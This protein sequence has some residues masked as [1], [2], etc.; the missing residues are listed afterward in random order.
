M[1]D[2]YDFSE[3]IKNPYIKPQKTTVTIRLDKATVDYFKGLS[4]EVN[5]PYQTLINAYLADCAA[6]Q[7]KPVLTWGD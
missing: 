2:E 1:Q 4:E 3:G 6:R 7:R 5:M